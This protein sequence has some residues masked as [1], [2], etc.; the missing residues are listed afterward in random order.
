MP[1]IVK[2]LKGK[3]GY[4]EDDR[5]IS[6]YWRC[7]IK[8]TV[9]SGVQKDKDMPQCVQSLFRVRQERLQNDEA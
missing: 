6:I 4:V 1:M 5:T 8:T 7:K 2:M 9:F 3:G